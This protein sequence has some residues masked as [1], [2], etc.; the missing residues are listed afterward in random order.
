M[1]MS[2]TGFEFGYGSGRMWIWVD[3]DLGGSGS[4]WM[5]I[6]VDMDL[7]GSGCGSTISCCTC[8]AVRRDEEPPGGVIEWGN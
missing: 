2:V 6:W 1:C 5:W 7:G 4:G 8:E 3:V